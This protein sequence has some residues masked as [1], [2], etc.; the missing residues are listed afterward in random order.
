LPGIRVSPTASWEIGRAG[1]SRTRRRERRRTRKSD[2]RN[3]WWRRTMKK[4]QTIQT[5]GLAFALGSTGWAQ[6]TQRVSVDS[7]GAQANSDSYGPSISADG[8]FVAFSSYA[9][10]LIP[11]DTNGVVDVFVRDRLNGTTERVSV[12]S[13]GVQGNGDSGTYGV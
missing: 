12:D 4:R 9:T 13:V 8:R 2:P 3:P 1:G 6:M 10:N 11:G 7:G 5:L